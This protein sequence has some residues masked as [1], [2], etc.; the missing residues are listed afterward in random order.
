MKSVLKKFVKKILKKTFSRISKLID[1]LTY[2][3]INLICDLLINREITER[4]RCHKNPLN[5]GSVFYGFSQNEEDFITLEII[6]RLGLKNGYFVEFGVGDGTENNSIILLAAGWKG[7]WFGGEDLAYD[8]S[9][10]DKVDFQKVWITKDNI[11]DIYKSKNKI[12]DIVSLDLDGNDFYLADELLSNNVKPKLF[13]IEYNAKFPPN[14]DFKIDYDSRHQW[15]GDDYFGASIKTFN[16]LF[17]LHGYRLICCNLT[18]SNA[19]F[20]K[21][22]FSNLFNDIPNKLEDIYVEPFYF[23]RRKKMH[24]TSI[25]TLLKIIN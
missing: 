11:F 20:V 3:N 10:S 23:Q 14:I 24:I 21:K 15:E 18:G 9:S 12:A 25:K 8:V 22:E 5:N 4:S 17:S 2:D 7:S 16:S 1:I 13:I 6:N 19:Y